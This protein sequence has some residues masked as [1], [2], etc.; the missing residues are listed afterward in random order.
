M[1]DERG[2]LSTLVA[3]IDDGAT[4]QWQITTETGST[5][6]GDTG[7]FL[8]QVRSDGVPTLRLTS[9][10][11]QI[12]QLRPGDARRSDSGRHEWRRSTTT[13]SRCR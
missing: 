3:S 12:S 7:C 8:V 9:H 6:V 13:S 4:G 1:A 11:T 5:Y 2:E 10:V